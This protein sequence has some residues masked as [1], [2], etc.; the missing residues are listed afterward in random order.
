MTNDE[1]FALA[2]FVIRHSSFLRLA[3][4]H[5]S[6]YASMPT[7]TETPSSPEAIPWNR[8]LRDI[9]HRQVLP[10]IGPGLIT[11][12]ENGRHLPFTHWLVPEF[13]RRLG[14]EPEP[15]MTLNRAACSH[16]VR[17]GKRKDIYEELREL[18]EQH[19]GLPVPPGLAELAAIRDFDLF[20]NSTFDGFLARALAQAR[21]GWKPDARG[22][23]AFHPSRP[24]DLPTPLPGTFLYHVLG[25]WD[26]YP[27]FAV[28]EEDYMEFLCGLLE[29][30]R[31][32]RLHL[33]RE[34]RNRSLLLIGAPFDDWIVRFFL[35]VAKQ[36]RLSDL[37]DTAA[38]YLADRPDQ[39]GEP[40]VFYFDKV[41]GSPQIIPVEP[42]VFAADLRR[43]WAEKYAAASTEDILASI[44]DDM[45][46]GAVFISYSHDDLAAVATLAAGLK[47]AGIPV[48]LDR[49]RL[50][51]GGDWEQAL[52]RAVKSRASLFLSLI[53]AATEGN[54]DRFVHEERK[55]AAE[56]HLDGFIF[57]IPVVID[58]TATVAREPAIFSRYHR[59]ALPGGAVTGD[60]AAL[61]E[62]YLDRYRDH[63]EVRDA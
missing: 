13:A 29:A 59:Y 16:L 32:T 49:R 47:A 42:R 4:R 5:R 57:Y 24:V 55:W 44:P 40:M 21:P 54:P 28:W 14:I 50:Q 20:V 11:V 15:G 33:F 6:P 30:P 56:R 61:L 35:R 63:G 1:E 8:I 43:R 23:A 10:V 17:K 38:D 37:R 9:H 2:A 52:K 12:E 41:I 58:G 46:R 36:G 31:D 19:A 53:S 26:T 39:L 34:L 48:W 25:A 7:N 3:R 45:E 60:F 51:A 62:R 18:V 27:D 22:R